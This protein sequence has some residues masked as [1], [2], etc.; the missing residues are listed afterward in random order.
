MKLN[1]HLKSIKTPVTIAWSLATG[2]E[3]D[4]LPGLLTTVIF[5]P[6]FMLRIHFSVYKIHAPVY[7]IKYSSAK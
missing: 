2:G 6:N 5:L 1:I 7:E 3:P 4:N